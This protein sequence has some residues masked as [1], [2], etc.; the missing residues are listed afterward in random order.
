MH[1][2]QSQN[3]SSH[4][5]GCVRVV[6]KYKVNLCVTG[7][8]FTRMGFGLLV[9]GYKT[10]DFPFFIHFLY[11]NIPTYLVR[12]VLDVRLGFY[13]LSTVPIKETTN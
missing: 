4:V 2:S 12:L 1:K 7:G 6:Q 13:T 11:T 9:T 8:D 3:S 5:V 10:M